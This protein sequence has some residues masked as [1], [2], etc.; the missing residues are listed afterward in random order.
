MII[1]DQNKCISCGLCVKDCFPMDIVMKEGRVAV[2]HETCIKCGHC[3]AVC[4][5]NAV[6]IDEYPMEEVKEYNEEEFRL[7][8]DNLLNF[9][10]YRRTIRQY[11]DKRVDRNDL[12][13]IMEA[14]RFTQTGSNQQDVTYIVVEEN[15]NELKE[16]VYTN[17][18][19]MG[20]RMLSQIPESEVQQ[21]RYPSMW[22]KMFDAYK[23]NPVK[24]DKLFFN[25]PSI[26]IVTATSELNG[27]LA[28]SNMELMTNALGLGTFFSGFF[29]F[30]AKNSLEIREYLKIKEPKQIV[31]CMVIG[32]PAVV[33]KRTVP[34]KKAEIIWK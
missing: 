1:I 17:L 11:Q 7:N 2:R 20:E 26:I 3:I 12:L 28:S 33:Y 22:V 30:A 13:K 23:E 16:L 34:R 5:N 15:L 9:I 10:K 24:N 18:K 4:P 6:S 27:G 25:A 14:G 19:H 32:H 29:V 31:S 21:R 8:A